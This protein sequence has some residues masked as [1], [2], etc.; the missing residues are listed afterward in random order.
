MRGCSAVVASVCLMS[1]NVTSRYLARLLVFSPAPRMV[2]STGA[3]SP[4]SAESPP[5]WCA[6]PCLFPFSEHHLAHVV[7][8]AWETTPFARPVMSPG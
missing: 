7:H 8:N 2:A 4:S 6:P 3:T 5:F 1:W